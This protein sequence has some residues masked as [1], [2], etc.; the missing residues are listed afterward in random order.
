MMRAY[1]L[2]PWGLIVLGVLHM[3]A[4]FRFHSTL[5]PAA[6]WFFN[7]GMVLVFTGVLNLINRRHGAEIAALR[8]FSV[9]VNVFLLGFAT[10][11]GLVSGAGLGELVVVVGLMAAIT[12]L[13][14]AATR[15]R[16][17]VSR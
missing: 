15:S 7:G 4:T 16:A 10:V 1:A 9:T 2:L 3:G 13:S 8:W 11:S 6:L 17:M 12:I 14:V 5:T